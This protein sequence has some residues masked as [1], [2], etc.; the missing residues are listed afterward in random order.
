MEWTVNNKAGLS[1]T[2]RSG[3]VKID[4]TPPVLGRVTDFGLV[5][6]DYIGSTQMP[7]VVYFSTYDSEAHITVCHLPDSCPMHPVFGA[8]I[9]AF[10]GGC[11]LCV[12]Q[13]RS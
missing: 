3:Y 5:D 1:T 8:L 9:G 4:L 7:I 2:V 10:N 11:I 12:L 13:V 6:V